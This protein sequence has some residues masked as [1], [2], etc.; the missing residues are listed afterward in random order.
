MFLSMLSLFSPLLSRFQR[1]LT[2]ALKNLSARSPSAGSGSLTDQAD[3]PGIFRGMGAPIEASDSLDLVVT[4]F[5]PHDAVAFII[6]DYSEDG[7]P[8]PQ[9]P[10][11]PSCPCP[12]NSKL[13]SERASCDAFLSALF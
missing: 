3:L 11:S 1:R 13:S 12:N 5:A 8:T 9:P 7:A 4:V 6:Y 10:P 2:V